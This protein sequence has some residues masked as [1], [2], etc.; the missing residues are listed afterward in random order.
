MATAALSSSP[1]QPDVLDRVLLAAII[2]AAAVA[3]LPLTICG[4]ALWILWTASP[5]TLRPP[6]L[7]AALV[8]VL[9][10]TAA[11]WVF[12]SE[13][14]PLDAQAGV[15]WLAGRYL[16]PAYTA[17]DALLPLVTAWWTAGTVTGHELPAAVLLGYA[18]GVWPFGLAG[19]GLVGIGMAA[20]ALS[21]FSTDVGPTNPTQP[22]DAPY[23]P[24]AER[25]DRE[26]RKT[27]GGTSW[28]VY[29]LVGRQ[30]LTIISGPYKGGKSTLVCALI[31]ALL[32]GDEVIGLAA[33][34]AQRVRWFTEESPGS[35]R[36]K[37]RQWGLSDKR[38]TIIYRGQ[39]AAV[40]WGS[41]L[42]FLERDARDGEVVVVDT[43][44]V[45]VSNQPGAE[46]STDVMTAAM[47]AA[48]GV[49]QRKGLAVVFVHHDN[50]GGKMRGSVAI[51]ASVDI[52]GHVRL[53]EGTSY[54]RDEAVRHWTAES[55][56]DE[57]PRSLYVRLLRPEGEA[58]RYEVL[59]EPEPE[60]APKK[61]ERPEKRP[62][63]EG[64]KLAALAVSHIQRKSESGEAPAPVVSN[65]VQPT[66][67]AADILRV[68][69]QTPGPCGA[70]EI[71]TALGIHRASLHTPLKALVADGRVSKQGTGGKVDPVRYA[72]AEPAHA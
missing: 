47:E 35:M 13:G 2:T 31:R 68:L 17:R 70:P 62:P 15:D 5:P 60:K 53:P 4:G 55:R 14:M 30:C 21:A 51:G 11:A 19:A 6:R 63:P 12:R 25:A 29:G 28:L 18:V 24:K 38:L 58:P 39:S 50:A 16:Q 10:L 48:R 65:K 32:T 7:A 8:G 69:E 42:A 72:I 33:T 49:A 52:I 45:H 37:L 3:L 61:R 46:N 44:A 34:K 67:R 71:A 64:G 27:G 54:E 40:S 41:L 23:R 22:T 57:T 26:A 43:L 9:C 36:Q 66:G 1:R 56:V 20:G 59:P